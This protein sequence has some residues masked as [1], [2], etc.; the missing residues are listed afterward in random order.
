MNEKEVIKENVFYACFHD[1]LKKINESF[2]DWHS[3]NS[4]SFLFCDDMPY[5]L[6]ELNNQILQTKYVMNGLCLRDGYL[7]KDNNHYW[8]SFARIEDQYDS[9]K[10][11]VQ[12]MSEDFNRHVHPYESDADNDFLK[13]IHHLFVSI[14]HV[15][16][17]ELTRLK[18]LD[19]PE[20]E[21]CQDKKQELLDL[22]HS[23]HDFMVNSDIQLMSKLKD[24][25]EDEEKMNENLLKINYADSNFTVDQWR[26]FAKK[27][28][29]LAYDSYLQ[30]FYEILNDPSISENEKPFGPPDTLSE[31]LDSGD[32]QEMISNFNKGPDG[33]GLEAPVLFSDENI[34][35]DNTPSP[36]IHRPE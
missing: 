23:F 32:M 28:I 15:N 22:M 34:P 1:C 36:I 6:K 27:E 24:F 8:F 9:I 31:F 5:H 25:S 12:S 18:K 4:G 17:R 10:K 11:M 20:F 14:I 26:E 30:S 3:K 19:I 16:K 2:E 21:E 33:V 35:A 29:Q 13:N 7:K